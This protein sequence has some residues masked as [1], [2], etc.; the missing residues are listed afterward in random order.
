[1][2]TVLLLET[3]YEQVPPSQMFDK[4]ILGV[5]HEIENQNPT[6]RRA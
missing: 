6:Q 4:L 1:M 3:C 5:P 2:D